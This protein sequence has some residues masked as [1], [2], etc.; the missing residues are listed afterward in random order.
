MAVDKHKRL[1]DLLFTKTEAGE[2]E[3]QET[4]E[5]GDYLA[6]FSNYSIEIT[7]YEAQENEST[8]VRLAIRGADGQVIEWV[9]DIEVGERIATQTEKNVFYR[10]T[11]ALYE[12][13]RRKVLGADKALDAILAEL[14]DDI[15][16]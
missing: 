5:K 16:F 14:D 9:T 3:W 2:L 12:M 6:S 7:R 13:V 15:P 11:E 10:K 4:A 1:F 8:I